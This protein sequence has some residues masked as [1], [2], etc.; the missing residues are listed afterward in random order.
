MEQQIDAF[1]NTIQIIV[2]EVQSLRGRRH[3]ECHAKY[4]WICVTSKIYN[5]SHYNREKIKRHLQG[6]WHNS[7][8]PLNN[9]TFYI[10]I[11]HLKNAPLLQI[12][13]IKLF[14]AYCQYFHLGQASRMAYI[15]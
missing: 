1:Y 5:D 4:Q 14:G 2:E 15:V 3:L 6:F 7:N 8:T 9:L 13:L 12:L 11:M 10:K